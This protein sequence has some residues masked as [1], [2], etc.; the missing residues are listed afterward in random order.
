MTAGQETI[1]D[2]AIH[3]VFFSDRTDLTSETTYYI[4]PS[5]VVQK[6]LQQTGVFSKWV[7]QATAPTDT[8]LVWVQN[9]V[10]PGV[11]RVYDSNT[12]SW[13]TATFERVFNIVSVMTVEPWSS[14]VS[15]ETGNVVRGS[16]DVI[17]IA[18]TP[19]GPPNPPVDPTGSG[20]VAWELLAPQV[21][22]ENEWTARQT[23]STN[24]TWPADRPPGAG[25]YDLDTLTDP[26]RYS[27][28]SGRDTNIPSNITTGILEVQRR[29]QQTL[30]AQILFAVDNTIWFR[31]GEPGS[32]E[33]WRE[34][35]F[36]LDEDH[37]FTGDNTFDGLLRIN[38]NAV[39]R[40][41][42]STVGSE[43]DLDT[44]ILSGRY[45][46]DNTRDTN[47]PGSETSGI[48]EVVSVTGDGLVAQTF[49]GIAGMW[50]RRGVVTGSS[51]VW[52][53]FV[54]F[55][56]ATGGGFDFAAAHTYTGTNTFQGAVNLDGNADWPAP[57]STV[58]SPY[59]LD[60]LLTPGRYGIDSA[61]DTNLPTGTTQGVLEV[62][63]RN[64]TDF[65]AQV[66]YTDE[67]AYYR[68]STEDPVNWSSWGN[69]RTVIDLNANLTFGGDNTY[70]GMSMLNG[71][72]RINGNARWIS[73]ASEPG[74]RF[75]AGNM[76]NAGRFYMG[77]QD[78]GKPSAAVG[79]MEVFEPQGADFRFALFAD[80]TNLWFR[81][82]D[83]PTGQ[84]DLVWDSWR[85]IAQF[86]LTVG[87]TSTTGAAQIP[88]GTTA[89]RP[90]AP[91]VGQFRYNETNDMFEG[92]NGSDWTSIGGT[93]L[94]PIGAIIPAWTT[95]A[96]PGTIRVT[97]SRQTLTRTMFPA[98][99]QH[100]QNSGN[101][102]AS[103]TGIAAYQWGPGNGS[104]TFTMPGLD[105]V[106]LR[107]SGTNA[108]TL[109]FGQ[110]DA[111]R[112]ISGSFVARN[113]ANLSLLGAFSLG[114]SASG[115]LFIDVSGQ[116][117]TPRR[118]N[119]DASNV[120]P[121]AADNRPAN[122]TV[123]YFI[124]AFQ[125]VQQPELLNAAD[126]IAQQNTNTTAIA[127]LQAAAIFSE[128]ATS[129]LFNHRR[130]AANTFLTGLSGAPTLVQARAIC[131]VAEHGYQV[132]DEIPLNNGPQD[133]P[134]RIGIQLRITGASVFLRQG[135]NGIQVFNTSAI[136]AT[137][138]NDNWDLQ[139][140]AW[141]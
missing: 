2:N 59:N 119:F 13:I 133:G 137:L 84:A 48:L 95:V 101:M 26:G 41:I 108:A 89:Q 66:F 132:G 35:I 1:F 16:D 79:V 99:F 104:T 55:A 4:H 31:T 71:T 114:A 91:Q 36:N 85:R 11:V 52:Q 134:G 105:G 94:F 98:L 28:D 40:S 122:A 25:G 110:T 34:V 3:R 112:N 93:G 18:V 78:T 42:A 81:R 135:L 57:V 39:W 9:D 88:A 113:P 47:L 140:R 121:T 49:T 30:R 136:G 107:A 73:E 6:A 27:I 65:Y 15:Y 77:T 115:S 63:R 116:V 97:T 90:S 68:S 20:Q 80:E 50:Y 12:S 139:L 44:L 67:T 138:S 92:Y 76:F 82:A 141:R 43:Y 74:A 21:D 8:S 120:V 46:I 37:T 123:N 106:F 17:Y 103:E 14:T 129:A 124:M 72:L 83:I 86:D 60:T 102:A 69:L 70:N 32:W 109:G 7:F 111:I 64:G 51:V 118:I 53:P 128:S 22:T 62:Q 96:P 23:F 100:A 45:S 125:S 54:Q 58:P 130:G 10:D 75:N 127:A 33:A 61:R 38:Q 87:Q 5:D 131:K 29:E 24:I 117:Q 19:T 56:T 126:V